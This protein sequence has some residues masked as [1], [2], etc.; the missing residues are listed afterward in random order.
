MHTRCDRACFRLLE[1]L[2]AEQMI[3]Y[4][5][6]E[7]WVEAKARVAILRHAATEGICR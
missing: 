4:A 2:V 6:L 3:V 1:E 5:S 7:R